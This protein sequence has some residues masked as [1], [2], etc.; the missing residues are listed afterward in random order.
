MHCQPEGIGGCVLHAVPDMAL[1]EEAVARGEVRDRAVLEF[2]GCCAAEQGDPFALVL[3]V[4]E[5]RAAGLAVGEDFLDPQRS[6]RQKRDDLLLVE[7]AVRLRE[8]VI[9]GE[10]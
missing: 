7:C 3:I 6:C 9:H 10:V 8:E 1:D 2:Q 4:P 5:I